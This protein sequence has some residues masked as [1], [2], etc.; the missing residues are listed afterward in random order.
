[1]QTK[2]SAGPDIELIHL[3]SRRIADRYGPERIMLFG[4]CASGTA[5]PDSD[6]DILVVMDVQGSRRRQTLDILR[7]VAD[8]DLPKDIFIATPQEYEK[9][10]DIPGTLTSIAFRTGTTLYDRQA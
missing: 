8:I 4:S 3:A 6:A 2:S 1:M 7:L 5:G 9:Y 10:R